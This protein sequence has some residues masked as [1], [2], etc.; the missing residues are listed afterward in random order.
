MRKQFIEI[1]NDGNQL[2]RRKRAE[3]KAPWAN[4]IIEVE[5]G[6]MAFESIEDA[7]SWKNQK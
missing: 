3:S 2:C 1:D 4:E 5:G 6:F 7:E